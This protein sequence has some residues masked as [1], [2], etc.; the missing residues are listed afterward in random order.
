MITTIILSFFGLS[1]LA[2]LLVF[3]SC[4][5]SSCADQI[6]QGAFGQTVVEGEH[7][8]VAEGQQAVAKPQLGLASSAL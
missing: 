2:S 1:C 6:T 8:V 7:F 3:A 5:A 4:V